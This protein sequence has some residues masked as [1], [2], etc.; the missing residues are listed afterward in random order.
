MA[1]TH[2]DPYF[3][4][5]DGGGETLCNVVPS[6]NSD[7][8]GDKNNVTCK[9]CL[10][11]LPN[12]DNYLKAVEKARNEQDEGYVDFMF[13][14]RYNCECVFKGCLDQL[15]YFV[16]PETYEHSWNCPTCNKVLENT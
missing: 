1:V 16:H 13:E 4:P 9:R 6:E 11:A 8:T 5:E 2:F 12:L 15:T 7:F 14:Q 10:K 3:D